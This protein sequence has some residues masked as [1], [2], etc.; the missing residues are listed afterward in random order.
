[1]STVRRTSQVHTSDSPRSPVFD[2]TTPQTCTP[3]HF[4]QH[5]SLPQHHLPRQH[6]HNHAPTAAA[7]WSQTPSTLCKHHPRHI[8]PQLAGKSQ[9]QHPA[10]LLTSKIPLTNAPLSVPS[11]K[12]FGMQSPTSMLPMCVTRFLRRSRCLPK[13]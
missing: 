9:T 10:S 3:H 5:F 1:M 8:G 6:G 12:I 13:S 2:I 11:W 7:S 4:S